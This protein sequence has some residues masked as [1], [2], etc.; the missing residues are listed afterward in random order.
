MKILNKLFIYFFCL[1]IL[2]GCVGTITDSK[3]KQTDAK[4][5]PT[6]ILTFAGITKGVGVAHNKVQL[7]FKP[8]SGWHPVFH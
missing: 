4:I 1:G 7:N 2:S 5:V 3:N 8:A 6:V